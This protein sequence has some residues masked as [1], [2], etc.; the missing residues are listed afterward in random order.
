MPDRTDSA[1]STDETPEDSGGSERAE[2]T[3]GARAGERDFRD[4]DPR[5]LDSQR[6]DHVKL[7]LDEWFEQVSTDPQQDFNEWFQETDLAQIPTAIKY[8]GEDPDWWWNQAPDERKEWLRDAYTAHVFG[9]TDDVGRLAKQEKREDAA[10]REGAP[11][12][13]EGSGTQAEANDAG[14]WIDPPDYQTT[15]TMPDGTTVT[16]SKDRN[17][18]TFSQ[19]DSDGNVTESDFEPTEPP[20]PRTGINW[21]NPV[22]RIGGF[23]MLGLI[24]LGGIWLGTTGGGDE[25]SPSDP[26][27]SSSGGSS[28]TVPDS[29]P[30]GGVVSGSV[31]VAVLVH[32]CDVIDQALAASLTSTGSVRFH[33]TGTRTRQACGFRPD[34]DGGVELTM[35]VWLNNAS[36]SSLSNWQSQHDDALEIQD[37]AWSSEGEL[38]LGTTTRDF[39]RTKL[40]AR[41]LTRPEVRSDVFIIVSATVFKPPSSVSQAS[42]TA[43]VETIAE[44]LNDAILE[45]QP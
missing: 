33:E 18:S 11:G 21:K 34:A 38:R 42:L 19:G 24:L 44:M 40:W 20:T 6:A 16:A 39:P 7:D 14:G 15:V 17:A 9:R 45:A 8:A 41:V 28:S 2:G 5:T 37:V 4:V 10:R 36:G 35:E 23:G 12:S 22:L 31:P 43:G 25:S 27:A 1:D 30:Q 29:T 3:E 32:P 26:A 13:S